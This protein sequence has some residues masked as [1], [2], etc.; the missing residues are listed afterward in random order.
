MN[1]LVVRL[2]IGRLSVVASAVERASVDSKDA[3]RAHLV[4]R[5]ALEDPLR[6]PIAKLAERELLLERA[7]S[8]SRS[9][10]FTRISDASGFESEMIQ[11]I[12]RMS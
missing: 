1:L 12:P 5:D 10:N 7:L 3:R 4:S 6:I 2:V 8:E 11:E 9:R